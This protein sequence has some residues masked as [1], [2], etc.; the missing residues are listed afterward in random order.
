[1]NTELLEGINNENNYKQYFKSK[2]VSC[3][4][5]IEKSWKHYKAFGNFCFK[6]SAKG[7]LIVD[8]RKYFSTMT[9]PRRKQHIRDRA[10]RKYKQAVRELADRFQVNVKEVQASEQA[11]KTYQELINGLNKG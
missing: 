6:C 9:N 1:M 4:S 10:E 7:S 8:A 2:C 5:P 3:R 11:Y